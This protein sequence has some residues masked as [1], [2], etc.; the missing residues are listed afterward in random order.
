[1]EGFCYD[2]ALMLWMN[3]PGSEIQFIKNYEN[4]SGHYVVK[5]R[6]KYYDIN[7]EFKMKEDYVVEKDDTIKHLQRIIN[8]EK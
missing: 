6:E 7:G 2:F 3:L 8:R 5:Y 1:M 4:N